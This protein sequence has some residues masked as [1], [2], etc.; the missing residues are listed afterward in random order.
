[1]CF[2][3]EMEYDVEGDATPYRVHQDGAVREV[4]RFAGDWITLHLFASLFWLVE[5]HQSAYSFLKNGGMNGPRR[6]AT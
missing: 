6:S 5:R 2:R 4:N 3:E 1:M